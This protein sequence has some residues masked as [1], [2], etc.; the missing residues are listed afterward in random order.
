M[1]DKPEAKIILDKN[2]KPC[3]TCNTLEDFQNASG[4][5]FSNLKTATSIALAGITTEKIPGSKTYYK[6]DPADIRQL[7][8]AGW[9]FLHTMTGK[10]PQ[11]PT[12]SEKNDMKNF[13]NLFSRVYPCDWC[14][15]DFEKYI[16]ENSPKV[17]SREELG[18][19]MCEAHNHV[20]K[21]LKKE[22]FDCN[23]WQQRWVVGWDENEETVKK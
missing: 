13:L 18:R 16:R 14:A 22:E 4:R 19:W 23:F 8:Q 12:P 3:R 1:S 10:Y 20:N 7:G 6:E 11:I 15:K 5:M 21:K 17:E 2:G 9:T